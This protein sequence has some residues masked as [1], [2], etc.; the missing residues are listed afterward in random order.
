[1]SQLNESSQEQSKM[2]FKQGEMVDSIE[3]YITDTK[4]NIKNAVVEIKEASEINK[5]SGTLLNKAI[6]IVAVIVGILILISI[7]MPN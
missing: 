2:V 3:T 7:I 5:S 4:D 1:M 6:C